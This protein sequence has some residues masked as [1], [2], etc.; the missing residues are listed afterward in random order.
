MTASSPVV[1]DPATVRRR[2][3]RAHGLGVDGMFLSDW[4]LHQIAERLSLIRRRF[5][6]VLQ[7]GGFNSPQAREALKIAAGAEAHLIVDT[8]PLPGTHLAAEPDMLPFPNQ[9]FDLIV[10]PFT[11]H[12]VNDLPGALLQVRRLLRPDGLF[13]AAMAGGETLHQLRA[14]LTEAEFSL[15]GGVSP[16]VFPFADKPEMGGLLQ[17][18]GFALPVVDSE[19]VTVTYDHALRLMADLRMMGEGN[20]IAG[21]HRGFAGRALFAEATRLY[22]DTYA[23]PDGRI[24][25]AFEII[26]LLGW[27]PHES[28]QKPSRRGSA[29]VSLADALGTKEQPAGE[30]VD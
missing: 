8:A 15:R 18:A 28:Q 14:C 3:L 21:R 7:L 24:P 20:S 22:H 27:A 6:R 9:S 25:A 4:C 17:R 16:R 10:S 13:L 30:A 1:F 11:L 29:T 26:F 5:P 2:R 23:E 12:S 19:I